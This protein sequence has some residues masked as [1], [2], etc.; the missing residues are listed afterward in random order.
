M[1]A[2]ELDE[3]DEFSAA[4]SDDLGYI[5]SFQEILATRR[6]NFAPDENLYIPPL[7][8]HYAMVMISSLGAHA[9]QMECRASRHCSFGH[10]F[11]GQ[12]EQ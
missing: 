6:V 9:P 1:S 4:Y 8:R 11:C 2:M 12:S 10:L 5:N 7:A 3:P